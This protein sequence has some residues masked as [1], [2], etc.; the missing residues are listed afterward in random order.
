MQP[1]IGCQI[2]VESVAR[3]TFGGVTGS[4]TLRAGPVYIYWVLECIMTWG[5]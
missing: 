3:G 2:F 1:H 5:G 4:C